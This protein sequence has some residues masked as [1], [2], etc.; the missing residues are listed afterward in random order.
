MKVL[1]FNLLTNDGTV[2]VKPFHRYIV[3]NVKNLYSNT[4]KIQ[5]VE[6]EKQRGHKKWITEFEDSERDRNSKEGIRGFGKK[7]RS[8]TVYL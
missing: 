8:N 7:T 3:Q 1:L 4:G 6:C 5:K 2:G